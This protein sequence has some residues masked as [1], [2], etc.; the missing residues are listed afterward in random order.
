MSF[1]RDDPFERREEGKPA[2]WA[3]QLV[4][5]LKRRRL[6]TITPRLKEWERCLRML[7]RKFSDEE[8]EGTVQWFIQNPEGHDLAII[9]GKGLLRFF[10]VFHLHWQRGLS[11][12]P[13]VLSDEARM[14]LD[15]SSYQWLMG[16]GAVFP[17]FIQRSLDNYTPWREKFRMEYVPGFAARLKAEADPRLHH[18]LDCLCRYARCEYESYYLREPYHYVSYWAERINEK[19]LCWKG[20]RG[21]LQNLA[22]SERNKFFLSDLRMRAGDWSG[23]AQLA[24]WLLADM[25]GDL[26]LE[27]VTL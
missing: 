25:R 18:K 20:W 26:K 6:I 15:G 24:D 12:R 22:W 10:G 8:I 17:L 14:I 2:Q 1:L 9:D 11:D 21:G 3:R 19:V 23:K 16:D 4:D 13:P 7:Q 5:E 27:E